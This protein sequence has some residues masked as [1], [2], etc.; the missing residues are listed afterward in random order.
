MPDGNTAA[1]R[2]FERDEDRKYAR[3]DYAVANRHRFQA[4]AEEEEVRKEFA[5]NL[6]TA[7]EHLEDR[8]HADVQP[9]VDAYLTGDD[10][11]LG[12]LVRAILVPEIADSAVARA[13]KFAAMEFDSG[14][15]GT[16]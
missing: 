9:F 8:L 3:D 4:E 5:G 2:R 7:A 12:R 13:E 1:L 15:Q 6:I 14:K 11:E 10:C 16:K